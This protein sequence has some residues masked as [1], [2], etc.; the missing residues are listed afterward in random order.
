MTKEQV[1][2][3]A[4][5]LIERIAK[6]KG[7]EVV[8]SGT[9]HG[10]DGSFW[11]FTDN[12]NIPSVKA[13]SEDFSIELRPFWSSPEIDV[14]RKKSDGEELLVLNYSDSVKNSDPDGR[15]EHTGDY[16][17]HEV[18]VDARWDYKGCIEEVFKMIEEIEQNAD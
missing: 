11:V 10:F 3:G 7:L 1:I 15:Y 12:S 13:K 14:I 2:R 16:R 5:T 8:N 9:G 17:V 6:E 4:I 18:R